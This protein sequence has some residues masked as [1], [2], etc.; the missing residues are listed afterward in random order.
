M[1]RRAF[2]ALFG[3]GVI[4]LATDWSGALS[5]MMAEPKVTGEMSILDVSIWSERLQVPVMLDLNIGNVTMLRAGM[6]PRSIFRWLG[7]PGGEIMM[8]EGDREICLEGDYAHRVDWSFIWRLQEKCASVT[9]CEYCG[10]AYYLWPA[11][12][13]CMSCGGA[14]PAPLEGGNRFV[15]TVND[16]RRTVTPFEVLRPALDQSCAYCGSQVSDHACRSC[17]AFNE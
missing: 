3:C 4:G 16:G 1:N 8:R 12:G 15:T 10:R 13:H 14:L 5:H 7:Y 9:G 2:L 6:A 17:G 11:G